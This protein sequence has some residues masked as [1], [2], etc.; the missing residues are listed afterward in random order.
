MESPSQKAERLLRIKKKSS[1]G[2]QMGG[3]ES[4]RGLRD[5]PAL[6][7]CLLAICS[8]S[9][10]GKSKFVQ[11]CMRSQLGKNHFHVNNTY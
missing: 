1:M 7:R 11:E 2:K 9:G 5:I 3:E 10:R 8:S 4:G 6:N